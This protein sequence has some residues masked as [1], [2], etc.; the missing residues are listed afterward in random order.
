MQKTEGKIPV[1]Y[2]SKKQLY[3]IVNQA[4]CDGGLMLL[5][6]DAGFSGSAHDCRMLEHTWI[7]L[8][9]E[10]KTILNLHAENINGC[11]VTPYLLGDPAYP[12]SHWIQKHGTKDPEQKKINYELSRAQYVI[13]KA[14]GLLK[15][16]NCSIVIRRGCRKKI[17]GGFM[18]RP[19]TVKLAQNN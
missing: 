10:Q 13:E 9:A 3:T 8:A 6:V 16:E 19:P 5:S 14:F 7:K 12:I 11:I 1:D 18:C 2:F 17:E 4:I 15:E